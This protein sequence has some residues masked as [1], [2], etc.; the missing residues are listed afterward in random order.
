[1]AAGVPYPLKFKYILFI[2]WKL[3]NWTQAG[4]Y[5]N[6]QHELHLHGI[7]FC[8][9]NMLGWLIQQTKHWYQQ[10]LENVIL[11]NLFMEMISSEKEIMKSF[12]MIS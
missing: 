6:D 10:P 2:T 1:M 12:S 5:D 3:L 7:I 4:L 8:A 11:K 9:C